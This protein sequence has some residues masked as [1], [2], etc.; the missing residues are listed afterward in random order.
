MIKSAEDFRGKKVLIMGLG[1]KGGGVGSVK[2]AYKHGAKI[3]VTDLNDKQYLKESLKEIEGIPKKLVLGKHS[4]NDFVTHDI[5][6][7]NPA[8]KDNNHYLQLAAENAVIIDSPIGIFSEINK[9]PYIGITGTKG[10][11]YTTSLTEHIL[12]NLDVKTVAAA[13]NCVSSLNFLKQAYTYVL[14]LS[15][16]QLREMKKHQKSPDISVWLNFFPD[17]LNYYSSTDEYFADKENIIKYQTSNDFCIVAAENTKLSNLKCYAKKILFAYDEK[18]IKRHQDYY[19]ACFLRDNNIII[20]IGIDEHK[21][22][23]L[24]NINPE[25]L[26]SHRLELLIASVCT[27]YFFIKE[28]QE[29]ID[30][31]EEKIEYAL[32]SFPGLENRYETIVDET[33]FKVINDSSAS[34]PESVIKAIE[35]TKICPIVLIAGGGGHKNLNF[36]ELT[37]KIV[38][39]NIQ[40]ILYN[41][42]ATSDIFIKHFINSNY[43]RYKSVDTLKRAVEAAFNEIKNR[44]GT[45]LLSPGCS[46]AP[47]FRDMF[48]RGE[49]FKN[50]SIAF[51]DS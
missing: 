22:I 28:Y 38:D 45:V 51:L 12:S 25:L 24:D 39:K 32:N 11:S 3:T 17:H 41:N 19:G 13:N 8:I 6:I 27:V 43:K 20:R 9:L 49:L 5:I 2:F 14:E 47:F 26:L 30:L 29:N 10:K 21:I 34:T 31:Q 42:D 4:E 46:G 37:Q 35:A 1:T 18:H 50:Y 33:G 48:E 23:S 7:K 36:D 16:W 15:S 44:K 40:V